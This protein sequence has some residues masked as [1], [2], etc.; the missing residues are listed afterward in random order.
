MVGIARGDLEHRDR[1]RRVEQ[2]EIGKHED[3]DHD[4][5]FVL[6]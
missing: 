3:A 2:L 5:H 4:F 1:T 6:K